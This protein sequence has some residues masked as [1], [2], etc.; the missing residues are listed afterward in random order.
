MMNRKELLSVIEKIIE[1]EPGSLHEED[2]LFELAAW[3]SIAF[4]SVIA[5]YDEQFQ[6]VPAGEQLENIK[7]VADLLALVEPRLTE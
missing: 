7:T 2:V 3:D 4:L 1:L 5:F 6:F